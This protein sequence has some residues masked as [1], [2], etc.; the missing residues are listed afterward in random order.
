MCVV[1]SKA[2]DESGVS[3]VIIINPAASLANSTEYKIPFS[4]TD[5][6]EQELTGRITFTTVTP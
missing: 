4:V 6:Y 2:S 5:I 3:T 1:L